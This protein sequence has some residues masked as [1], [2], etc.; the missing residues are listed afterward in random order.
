[1]NEVGVRDWLES[2]VPPPPPALANVLATVV[3]D[4]SCSA[5]DIPA[6]LVERAEQLIGELGSG[7]ESANALLAA[8]ALITYAL[9]AAAENAAH[10]EHVAQQMMIS[11]AG[12]ADRNGEAA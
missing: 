7:R 9:E 1:M 6:V 12:I 3:G 10:L 2:R 5:A 4:K 11:I 8:D